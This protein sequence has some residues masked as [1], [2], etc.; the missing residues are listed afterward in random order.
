MDSHLQRLELQA[1]VADDH[2]F[3]IED[4]TARQLRRQAGSQLGEVPIH[5]FLIAAL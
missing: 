5:R 1:G 3:A 2:Y 4:A